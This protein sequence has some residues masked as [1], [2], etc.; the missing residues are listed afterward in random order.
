[1]S[2]QS[3]VIFKNIVKVARESGA[4]EKQ[5]TIIENKVIDQGWHIN[6]TYNLCYASNGTST[7]G[8]N[9]KEN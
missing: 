3:K 8:I 2:A 4:L 7:K 5:I 6:S 1:M 9:N